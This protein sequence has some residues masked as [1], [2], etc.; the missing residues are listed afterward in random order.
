M[1]RFLRSRLAEEFHGS[2]SQ[3]RPSLTISRQ[4]GTGTSRLERPLVEYLD[5]ADESAVHGWAGFDQSLIGKIIEGHKL[6]RSMEPYLADEAKFPVFETLEE[7]LRLQPSKW[8]L[9]NYSAA[10]IRTLCRMGNALVIGRA[11]NFVSSDLPNTFHVRLIG[12]PLKRI[13]C[14]C[15]RFKI[16]RADAEKLIDRTDRSR[17]DFVKRYTGADIDD[18]QAYHLILNT[19]NLP[20][21][22][23]VRIIGDSLIE[24]ANEKDPSTKNRHPLPGSL[25]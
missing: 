10:T 14:V 17:A 2:D 3:F 7:A 25:S 20:D 22:V 6:P 19:D 24:W 21:E 12:S 16:T 8:T 1:E 18:T 13:A 11:G 23:I 15:D 5:I 4:C 9:F